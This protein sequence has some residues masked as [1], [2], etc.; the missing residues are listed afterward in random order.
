MVR[1]RA[2]ALFPM[3]RPG[4]ARLPPCPAWPG[5]PCT[6]PEHAGEVRVVLHRAVPVR[7]F[8]G[9]RS[10]P[11]A[12]TAWLP[13]SRRAAG[14]SSATSASASSVFTRLSDRLVKLVLQTTL[15]VLPAITRQPGFLSFVLR[16][17]CVERLFVCA[18]ASLLIILVR[19]TVPL[20]EDPRAL[21]AQQPQLRAAVGGRAVVGTLQLA[22]ARPGVGPGER[23]GREELRRGDR[24]RARHVAAHH[25]A[26]RHSAARGREGAVQ[27]LAVQRAR[28]R[29]PCDRQRGA[30]DRSGGCEEKLEKDRRR[31]RKMLRFAKDFILESVDEIHDID[32]YWEWATTGPSMFTESKK[33]IGPRLPPRTTVQGHGLNK[34]Q[35]LPFSTIRSHLGNA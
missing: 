24:A 15:P 8:Q 32:I 11:G 9:P 4:P 27:A 16:D 19:P 18:S 14:W 13:R 7:F 25:A 28:G 23:V 30:R 22:P 12:C 2:S 17:S 20:Q 10:C 21:V 35:R 34:D 6:P 3:G 5:S 26:R 29:R 1:L 33:Y 31:E